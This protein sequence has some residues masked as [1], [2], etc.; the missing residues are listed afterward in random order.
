MAGDQP[1]P[2][3]KKAGEAY[4]MR[5]AAVEHQPQTGTR[6][7]RIALSTCEPRLEA[8]AAKIETNEIEIG[9]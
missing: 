8:T 6:R 5:I 7:A 4:V 1:G 9:W 2:G 3:I